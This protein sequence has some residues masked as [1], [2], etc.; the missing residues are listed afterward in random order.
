[1][2]EMRHDGSRGDVKPFTSKFLEESLGKLVLITD[3]E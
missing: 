1:M 2:Q 3:D